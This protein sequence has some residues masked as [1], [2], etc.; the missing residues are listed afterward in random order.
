MAILE[1]YFASDAARRRVLDGA[2]LDCGRRYGAAAIL[3]VSPAVFVSP[4]G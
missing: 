4:P 3:A 2:V 1:A